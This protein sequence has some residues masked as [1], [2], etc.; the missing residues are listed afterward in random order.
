MK[1]IGKNDSPEQFI[2]EMMSDVWRDQCHVWIRKA[3]YILTF[4]EK[5][6]LLSAH[7]A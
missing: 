1:Y 5:N 3:N 6:I 4:N 7:A 2:W